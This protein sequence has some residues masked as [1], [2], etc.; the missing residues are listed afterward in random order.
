MKK[1]KQICPPIHGVSNGLNSF[2]FP[3]NRKSINTIEYRQAW[4]TFINS[5]C[6]IK[7]GNLSNR[8]KCFSANRL[9]GQ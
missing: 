8:T 3:E 1:R 7:S 6:I 5:I 9:L 4:K 2:T